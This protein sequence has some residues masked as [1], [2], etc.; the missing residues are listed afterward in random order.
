MTGRSVFA[1]FHIRCQALAIVVPGAIVLRHQ[2]RNTPLKHDAPDRKKFSRS[3]QRR[4]DDIVQAALRIFD[5]DGFETAKM[6]D[7]AHEAEVAKGTLYLYFDTKTALL[8]AVILTS[9]L[10][11]LEE[12]GKAAETTTGS[13]RDLLAQQMFIAAR[14][15]ASPEMASLLRHMISGRSQHQEIIK[16]YYDKVIRIGLAHVGATLERGVA[17]GEFRA[18]VKDADPLILVGAHVY[19]TVWKILFDDLQ[20]INV[21]QL[22]DRHLDLILKGLLADPTDNDIAKS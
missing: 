18:E 11:T 9:I 20:E 6:S 10:P 22:V 15:M 16:L 17:S 8:E 21:E 14:R 12:M 3:Q 2:D 1:L 4:H 5:R 19:T 13:A 7:I